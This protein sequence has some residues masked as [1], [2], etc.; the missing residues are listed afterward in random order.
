MADPA[1]RRAA[2]RREAEPATPP[3]AGVGGEPEGSGDGRSNMDSGGRRW[4]SGGAPADPSDGPQA[5]QSPDARAAEPAAPGGEGG[6]RRRRRQLELGDAAAASGSGEGLPGGGAPPGALPRWSRGDR[7]PLLAERS[8]VV[9]EEDLVHEGDGGAPEAGG[10]AGLGVSVAHASAAS[11]S[12]RFAEDPVH[13]GFFRTYDVPAQLARSSADEALL[14]SRAGGGDS[15]AHAIS[16]LV[17][18]VLTITRGLLAGLSLLH[19]FLIVPT[20]SFE[21]PTPFVVYAPLALRTQS[22]F[23]A[24]IATSLVAV[25]DAHVMYTPASPASPTALI[26]ASGGRGLLVPTGGSDATRL[27]ILL[28]VSAL[29]LGTLQTPLDQALY[30]KFAVA[31]LGLDPLTGTLNPEPDGLASAGAVQWDADVPG[32]SCRYGL[33]TCSAFTRE[34]AMLYR[35]LGIARDTLCIAAFL[36]ATIVF[37]AFPPSPRAGMRPPR[38]M[39][40]AS[41]RRAQQGRVGVVSWPLSPSGGLGV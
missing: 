39:P 19:L 9:D 1:E 14:T 12:S 6:T 35:S 3:R 29:L 40:V 37:A 41:F 2:R 22:I 24:L 31:R 23:Q 27:I 8:L 13:G 38:S 32:A 18:A 17:V 20:S 25:L 5:A 16:R 15:L 10:S 33:V 4:R 11:A 28:Y 30:Y 21:L 7:Q 36:L 34:R 26:V